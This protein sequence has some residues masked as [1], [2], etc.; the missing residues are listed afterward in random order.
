MTYS[1]MVKMGYGEQMKKNYLTILLILIITIMS[2]CGPAPEPTL[3]TE[4]ISNTAIANAWIAM[5]QTQAA[6][7]TATPIPPTFTLEPTATFAPTLAPLPTL[8]LAAAAGPT[9]DPCNQPPSPEPK[10]KLVTVEFKNDSEGQVNLA[11]GMNT[12]NDK[13]ECVTYSYGLGRGDTSSTKVLIGCY[14]GYAWITGNEP[15]VART[16][17]KILCLTDSNLTYHVVITKERI[18]FKY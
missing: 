6:L 13:G 4:E 15:S 16:G 17:S 11:F 10:G 9:T 8:T 7:P 12:P 2:A 1:F 5:T 3:T 18:E 14:W